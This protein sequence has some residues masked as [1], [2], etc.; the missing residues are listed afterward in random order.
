MV[1]KS[2]FDWQTPSEFVTKAD[3]LRASLGKQALFKKGIEYREAYI[4][5]KFANHVS[6]D[7]VKLLR[8]RPV[9]TPDFAVRHCG[10]EFWFES[11][12]ADRPSRKRNLEYSFASSPESIRF[13]KD[14]EWVSQSEYSAEI[15]RLCRQKSEKIY[16]K[17][18][19]LILNSNAFGIIDEH[20]MDEA[21]WRLA[22]QAALS[23]FD[24]VWAFH[25]SNFL[26]ITV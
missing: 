23:R 21:W 1:S 13:L 22:T 14:D 8:T 24:E 3:G 12:E 20:L 11:T 7:S 9:P 2:L 17:C 19:G 6:S 10:I 26:R 15:D 16:D 4:A 25:R 18:D 5:G